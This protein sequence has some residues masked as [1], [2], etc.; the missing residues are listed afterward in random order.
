MTTRTND[1]ALLAARLAVAALFLPAGIG[2]LSGLSGFTAML[3]SKGVPFPEILAV[4]GVAAEVLGPIALILGVAPRLTAV[5]LI[6]FTL[7]ASLISHSFWTF[8]DAA[9]AAQQQTQFFKNLAIV[10]GLLFYFVSGAGAF[11]LQNFLGSRESGRGIVA[12]AE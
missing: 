11:S 4:L 3:A 9:Q 6:G 7:V 8:A 12:P 2:K 10:G 5:L 1:V